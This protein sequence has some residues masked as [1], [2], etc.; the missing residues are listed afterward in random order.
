MYPNRLAAP[1]R[2]GVDAVMDA[3]DL[4]PV[5]EALHRCVVEAVAGPAHRG[6]NACGGK[7]LAAGVGGMRDAAVAAMNET[8]RRP[9][10]LDRHVQ[11][12]EGD[13]GVQRLAHRPADDLAGVHVDERGEADPR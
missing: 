7:H 13:P 10:A 8:W 9:L 2:G 11:R 3:L 4:E 1:R 6:C 5:E 12:L